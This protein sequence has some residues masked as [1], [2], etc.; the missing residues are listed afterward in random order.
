MDGRF[1]IRRFSRAQCV[2]ILEQPVQWSVSL[3]IC[4]VGR[5]AS[6]DKSQND[7]KLVRQTSCTHRIWMGI[8]TNRLFTDANTKL[9]HWSAMH[10]CKR[11]KPKG[12]GTSNY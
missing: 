11:C 3:H 1:A 9:H 12:H 5:C 6:D 7:S 8:C 2:R 10:H 4:C